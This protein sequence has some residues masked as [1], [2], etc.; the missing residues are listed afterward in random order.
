M[1]INETD[2]PP[3]PTHAASCN[4]ERCG[5]PDA[6]KFGDEWICVDCYTECGSCCAGED[7]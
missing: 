1:E 7:E 3:L 6:V 4:C 2:A 5:K